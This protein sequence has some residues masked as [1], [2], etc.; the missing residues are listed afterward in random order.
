MI[1]LTD[2]SRAI[3]AELASDASGDFDTFDMTDDEP[4][5]VPFA[6]LC[7]QCGEELDYTTDAMLCADCA[8][9]LHDALT[10]IDDMAWGDDE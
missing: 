6:P 7:S 2:D 8:L 5:I 1:A 10:T 9:D 3:L 4:F